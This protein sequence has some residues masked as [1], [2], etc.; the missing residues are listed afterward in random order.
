MASLQHQGDF[1]G[2]F[3]NSNWF[4]ATRRFPASE[5]RR[6][7]ENDRQLNRFIWAHKDWLNRETLTRLN[8]GDES[9][10]GEALMQ[11]HSR[12]LGGNKTLFYNNISEGRSYQDALKN[13]QGPVK[14]S[15]KPDNNPNE[16]TKVTYKKKAS[17]GKAPKGENIFSIFLHNIPDEATGREIW[18]FFSNCGNFIDIILPK[19]RDKNGKRIG[20]I[21]TTSE[22]EAGAIISN[23]KMNKGL[24]RKISMS[25]NQ[26]VSTP[27]TK[28]NLRASEVEIDEEVERALLDSKIGYSWFDVDVCSVRDRL[29]AMGL[30]KYRV[31][32]LSKRKFMISKDTKESWEDLDKSDLSVWFSSIRNYEEA[33]HVISRVVW[34]ECK[35]LPMPAWREENLRAFTDGLGTWVNWSYQSDS[36]D[37]FFN[38]LI[39]IDTL[40]LSKI[41][42]EMTILYKGSQKRISFTEVTDESYLAGKMSPMEF[43][44]AQ[45]NKG[46]SVYGSVYDG[47]DKVEVSSRSPQSKKL[48]LEL[49]DHN[50]NNVGN[51]KS[52]SS[53]KPRTLGRVSPNLAT[54]GNFRKNSSSSD[55]LSAGSIKPEI[56]LK[57]ELCATAANNSSQSTLCSGVVKKLRVKSRRGRPKKAKLQLRNPFDIGV[58]FKIK[59]YNS[60]GNRNGFRAKKSHVH[61]SLQVI[62]N[63]VVGSSVK[64]A[65]EII[66]TAENM[67]LTIVG[68]KELVAQEIAKKLEAGVL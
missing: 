54:Q 29:R 30:G 2:R 24:G 57:S 55:V 1:S 26:M 33:D 52:S 53:S 16:W 28:Q 59:K 3:Q 39:C 6:L 11:I 63:R 34:I 35:G 15:G 44:E 41:E 20:F 22:V 5:D 60:G 32:A 17:V 66:E 56:W 4:P 10:I 68:D 49:K 45:D 42:E 62:P 50:I 9:A 13:T 43:S 7:Q 21:H 37:S 48:R 40:S 19:K 12:S 8:V 27:G 25:I 23:A 51:S 58:K 36:L 67:G 18:Q 46:D 61:N 14:G 65:L 38:P 64:E 31:I 47:G